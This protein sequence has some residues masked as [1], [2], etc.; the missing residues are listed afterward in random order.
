MDV[1]D[2]TAAKGRDPD[3]EGSWTT[4]IVF[5]SI[6]LYNVLELNFLIASTFKKYRGLY[7]WSL[8]VSTWGVAFNAVGYLMRT[9]RTDP[10][11]YFHSTIILIGWCTMVTGQ[12]LVMY[13]R[14]HFV[15]HN[16][17]ILRCVLVMIITNSVWLGVPV[18]VLVYGTNSDN[19][20]PF[21]APYSIFEKLQLSV[22]SFQEMIISGLY[23]V[24]TTKTLKLQRSI[25]PLGAR[26]VLGHL[27]VV[28]FFLVLLDASILG[29]EFSNHYDIQTAWKPLVY[30]VKL[31]V[32]FS[33]LNRLVEFSQ[34]VKTGSSMQPMVSEAETDA[35]TTRC[36][37]LTACASPSETDNRAHA[38]VYRGDTSHADDRHREFE[39]IKTTEF[40]ISRDRR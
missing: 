2:E 35:S 13:S 11:G 34:Q 25:A 18:I 16:A 22:F 20:E 4:I 24:E 40:P 9:L 17:M 30:S 26:N 7:F 5:V 28:N 37:G 3:P 33:V 21:R 29:L 19:P 15:L 10:S 39:V 6:A 31:K 23:I 1:L 27:L 8:M 14:L 36:S 38:D 32:E 12:S